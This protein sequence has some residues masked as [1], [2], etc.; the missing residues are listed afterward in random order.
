MDNN[1]ITRKEAE[2]LGI[3][4]YFTGKPCKH[5]HICE[6]YTKAK[7]CVKCD[8]EKNKS[9]KGKI[10]RKKYLSLNSEKVSRKFKEY[11][12]KNAELLRAKK[13]EYY[14]NN[15]ERIKAQKRTYFQKNKDTIKK[16][17]KENGWKYND[18]ARIQSSKRRALKRSAEGNYTLSDVQRLMFLQHNQCAECKKE[19]TFAKKNNFH[20]DHIIPL[21]KGGS[22][23]PDNLQ[24]LC[25]FCNCSKN[26]LLPFEWAKKKY[27]FA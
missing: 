15:Q 14:K 9:N 12:N 17:R 20:V 7:H 11:W 24:L 27:G 5:G 21:S 25:V 4:R 1:I 2:A 18:K 26:N 19:I 23:W 10:R 6:R 13:R 16:K 3:G 22:N 8:Y